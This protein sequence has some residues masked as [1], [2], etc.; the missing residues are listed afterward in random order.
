[1]SVYKKEK[2]AQLVSRTVFM[3]GQQKADFRMLFNSLP[4]AYIAL[5]PDLTVI[6]ASG[7]YTAAMQVSSNE[8]IG[9]YWLDTLP[10]DDNNKQA[11]VLYNIQGALSYI[12]KNKV[13]HLLSL[14]RID[15]LKKDG[16][17][18]EKYWNLTSSPILNETNE[19]LYL[20][21]KLEDVTDFANLQ[22]KQKLP[23]SDVDREYM[24]MEIEIMR[25]SM[26]V[27]Q[28]NEDLAKRI[29]E[30][31]A[32][33]NRISKDVLDYKHALEV[34]SIISVTD[35]EGKIEY[36]NQ[37]FCDV[38]QYSLDE[39]KH[40]DHRI[41]NS[42]Y[43][44]KEFFRKL[45][46]TIKSGEVWKG[47]IKNRAKDGSLYWLDTTIVPFLNAEGEPYKFLSIHKDITK[48]KQAFDKI[49]TS[50]ANYK[51][52]FENSAVSIFINDASGTKPL[53]V[54]SVGAKTFGYKTKREFIENFNGEQHYMNP[55]EIQK[56]IELL[57]QTGE[58][59][60]EVQEMKRLNGERFWVS[61]NVKLNSEKNLMYTFLID[62]TKQMQLKAEVDMKVKEL[63]S[64]N[65]ELEVFN[66]ISTHDLQEP[67]RK[68]Q[69]FISVMLVDEKA[70]LSKQGKEYLKSCYETSNRMRNLLNDL[71]MYSK[72]KNPSQGFEKIEFQ[73]LVKQVIKELKQEIKQTKA[74]L[75]LDAACKINVIPFQFR[76]VLHNL[77]GNALKF[78]KPGV[79]PHITITCSVVKGSKLKIPKVQTALTYTHISVA[80]NGI[81]FDPRYR[82][83][84]F[85]VFQRLY[86]SEY[87]EGTGI[88]LAICKRIVE[89]HNGLI[90]ASSK[91]GKG[92][93]FDIY[94]PV[95][96]LST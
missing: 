58:L 11:D 29:D 31:V 28:R 83:R 42:G 43:H 62:I 37:F 90:F 10:F 21:V 4:C 18:E 1:M 16:T 64:K 94:I 67:L 30:G 36:V 45:W 25:R 60:N 52:L 96:N 6:E 91:P 80:D 57:Q 70:Y 81:G 7:A 5:W 3:S 63:E 53:A 77:I 35:S 95:Y 82:E 19:V 41:V 92:A 78:I 40:K 76:Q 74:T 32:Q 61:A 33:I 22:K 44:S 88:G 24:E 56:N 68:I 2:K 79:V 12:L 9:K 23:Q 34:S 75:N 86:T 72:V 17:A 14:Q 51:D 46:V 55:L 27:Q 47:E 39:L 50:E 20:L 85:E 65:K 13:T 66:Y 89:N 87:Y 26:E 71:L 38:S 8:L 15:I 48:R 59:T 54:N 69:N 93:K 84:I 73:E 49:K